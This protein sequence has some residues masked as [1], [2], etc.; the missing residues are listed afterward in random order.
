MKNQYNFKKGFRRK[1][2]RP[3]EQKIIKIILDNPDLNSKFEIFH[4]EN[5]FFHFRLA[6]KD[7]IIF[8]SQE[9]KSK[10]ECEHAINEIRQYS[11][12]ANTVEV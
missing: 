10:N 2:Y 7:K 1:F 12:I 9:Y 4:D 8:T 11:I 6:T 5:G 3:G